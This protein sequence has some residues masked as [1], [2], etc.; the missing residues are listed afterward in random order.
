LDA[1]F[2]LVFYGGFA[3]PFLYSLRSREWLPFGRNVR[4]TIIIFVAI[5]VANSF[6]FRENSGLGEL[7]IFAAL[8]PIAHLVVY[9]AGHKMFHSMVGRA[10]VDV[11]F[12]WK[13]GLFWDRCFA[14]V[15]IGG[16]SVAIFLTLFIIAA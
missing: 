8:A 11:T 3:I 4:W 16:F 5:L 10:P 2:L 15:V 9:A 1:K 7:A 13:P 14:F 6:L 12:N